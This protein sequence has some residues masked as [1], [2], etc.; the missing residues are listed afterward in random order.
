MRCYP[1]FIFLQALTLTSSCDF[2][3][4]TF[5]RYEIVNDTDHEILLHSYSRSDR[6][7]Q[8]QILLANR[9]DKWESEKFQT[10]EPGGG[11]VPPSS[12][13]EGDSIRI[14]FDGAKLLIYS[15]EYLERNILYEE[16][17]EINVLGAR[18]TARSF[19]FTESDYEDAEE[20]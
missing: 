7:L 8:K 14:S 18:N 4:K 5:S 16:N 3:K 19:T 9:G 13:L 1:I 2:G 12:V 20:I 6:L 17:Y 15:R 10:S 11:I